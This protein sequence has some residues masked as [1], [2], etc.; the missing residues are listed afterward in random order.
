MSETIVVGFGHKARNGKNTAV[1]TII[2]KFKD[3]YDIREYSFAA[4]LK[5]EVNEA[6]G[7]CGGLP[8]LIEWLSREIGL[9]AYVKLDPN[10]DM[11]DP[12]CPQ[13]KHRTLLQWWG[14]EYRRNNDE[15][16][17]VKKLAATI[18]ADNPQFALISDMRFPNELAWVESHLSGG[19]SV[20]V[21]RQGYL[22]KN[23]KA[24]HPSETALDD[25]EFDIEINVLDGELE[26]LKRSAVAAFE[27]I[28]EQFAVKEEDLDFSVAAVEAAARNGGK[29]W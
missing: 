4:A 13:G 19:W 9:P 21:T 15:E 8:Q 6:A 5:R 1:S 25:A 29:E 26:D 20:K 17:W 28:I 11:T 2:E 7:A 23:I 22:D 14:T 27:H 10:P 16:Y 18:K 24:D 3:T 12:M